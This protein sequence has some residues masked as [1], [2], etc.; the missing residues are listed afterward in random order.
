M[1]MAIRFV[2]C[3]RQKLEKTLEGRLKQNVAGFLFLPL[4]CT[5]HTILAEFCARNTVEGK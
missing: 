5:A 2:L 3:I 4:I 1:S